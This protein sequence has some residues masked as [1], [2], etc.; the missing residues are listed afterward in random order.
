MKTTFILA[1]AA[2]AAFAVPAAAQRAPRDAE[3]C[4]DTVTGNAVMT[5]AQLFADELRHWPDAGDRAEYR[6][7]M[8]Q[9]RL[10]A[11]VRNGSAPP[12]RLSDFADPVAEVPWLST[13]DPW[14]HRVEFVREGDGYELRSAGP[15]GRMFTPDDVSKQG[16]L[17]RERTPPASP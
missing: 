10:D 13:C 7:S 3:A 16:L 11:R 15:D 12:Q 2:L 17:P 8:L 1:A 5:P 9:E 6:L 4:R 14:G